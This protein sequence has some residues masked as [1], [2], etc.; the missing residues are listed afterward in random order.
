MEGPSPVVASAEPGLVCT[1]QL[2]TTITL[3][4]SGLSPLAIDALTEDPKL[5][6]PTI[7]LRRTADMDGNAVSEDPVVIPDDPAHP[8]QSHVRWLS[9][10]SMS[11]E[12]YPELGLRPGTYEITVRNAN[13]HSFTAPAALGAIPPPV[14]EAV[15]PDLICLAEGGRSLTLTGKFFLRV[16]DTVPTVEIDGKV[17]SVDTLSGC[18]PAPG[19]EPGAQICTQATVTVP[20][21]DLLLGANEVVLHNPAPAGCS[22]TLTVRVPANALPAGTHAVTV[23]NPAPADCSSSE[24]VML[25]VVG[26]PEITGMVPNPLCNSQGDSTIEISGSGFLVVEGRNPTVTIDGDP[27]TVTAVSDCTPVA[28]TTLDAQTCTSITITV[29]AGTLEEG[30]HDVVVT[31]PQP[32]DCST[33]G[34]ATLTVVPRPTVTGI[35]PAVLCT[36]GGD[37]TVIGTGFV[38][39]SR[40]SIDGVAATVTGITSTAISVT[41]P[42]GLGPGTH[43]VTV[44]SG[45]C[46]DTLEAGLTITSGPAV[47]FVDPPVVYSGVTLQATIWVSGIAAA[48][49]SVSIRP[50]SG[51][52]TTTLDH[53][54]DPLHPHRIQAIVPQG[55]AEGDYDVIVNDGTCVATLPRGL[56]VTA[57]LTVA[58]DSITPPFGWTQTDT[59]VTI[60]AVDPAPAGMVQFQ[61]TPR[62]YLNPDVAGPGTLA[63]VLKAVAFVDPTRLTAIVPAGLPEGVY[64]LIV[65]NP[66]GTVGLLDK[67]FTVTPAAAPPPEIAAV[68]PASVVNQPGQTIE[69]LG[70]NFRSPSVT[71]ICKDDAGTTYVID[72]TQVTA[73]ATT[74]DATFDMSALQ[75]GGI[76]VVRV[77]N[78]DGTYADYSAVAVTNPAQN[79]PPTVED[80][81]MLVPRRALAL[82]A[83]RATSQ[84]R[85][86]YAIGGDAGTDTGLLA[87]VE[88]APVDLYGALNPWFMLPLSL[89]EGRSLA[90]AVTIGRFVYLVGGRVASGATNSV[91]RAQILDPKDAPEIL[92]LNMEFAEAGGLDAGLWYYRVS[93]VMDA[94]DPSNP[95]GETLASDPLAVIVP[96]VPNKVDITI[97]WTA[98][99]G[100]QSYRVY[101]T[102]SPNQLV[103]EGR[104]IATVRA[105]ET[106]YL[107]HGATAGNEVPLPLGAL[108][109]WHEV[110]PL[111]TAREGAAVTFAADPANPNGGFIL[112]AIGGRNDAGQALTTYEYAQITVASN[113]AQTVGA[114]TGGGTLLAHG[115]WQLGAVAMDHDR[116]AVVPTGETWIYALGGWNANK[117]TLI[118][119]VTAAKVTP[120]GP[121]TP[122]YEV[123]NMTPGQAGYGFAG[124]NGFLFAFGGAAGGPSNTAVSAKVCA[125]G[126]PGCAGS[127]PPEPPDLKNWNNLGFNLKESRYLCGSGLESAF[128]FLAGG[129]TSTARAT[130][131]VERTHW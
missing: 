109:V 107:D 76:C 100:A 119:D 44:V 32:A 14:L 66:D 99:P 84:A 4:G 52:S 94:S 97:Y 41:V 62:V 77:T 57:T 58:I 1:D 105:S 36:G 104:L 108:G 37:L 80:D 69:I 25:A 92:D 115:R 79:L 51:G 60:R 23:T 106:S 24:T 129:Q 89:P 19:K 87:S 83:G 56:H 114:F 5:A 42:P 118:T 33:T 55:L 116:A 13:G 63:S 98:V 15:E 28:G 53:T 86:L 103:G 117:S 128:I 113:G 81:S 95:G 126:E 45:G 71:A 16:G 48:P 112:Y 130:N 70:T 40:V 64:D 124:A 61:A 75:G 123:D 21:G 11:F 74:L 34:A 96:P 10:T 91:L 17:Y 59:A 27:A 127:G 102:P 43:D 82:T 67:A 88:A 111:T 49:A 2:T 120:G 90:G 12:V 8:T 31:N 125:A 78:N 68:T 110:G 131:S 65:V 50:S 101:R 38:A 9:Q 39:G 22:S 6:L 3:T 85:F 26:P 30:T 122:V 72:G 93:A 18:Q 46:S 47:Y 54:W 35:T 73:T 29:P 7:L 20:E 121:L